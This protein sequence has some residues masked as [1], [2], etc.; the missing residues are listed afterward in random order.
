MQKEDLTMCEARDLLDGMLYDFP[1]ECVR[2][3]LTPYG[4]NV[5]NPAFA[6]GVTKVCR[7]QYADLGAA[8]KRR[9]SRT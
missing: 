9:P 1:E 7:R 8:E 5:P 3:Y 4:D 2:K 6:A